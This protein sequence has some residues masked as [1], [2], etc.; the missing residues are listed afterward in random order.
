MVDIQHVQVD[1]DGFPGAP[2][3]SSFYTTD[4]TILRPQLKIFFDSLKAYLP[5]DVT[6]TYPASGDTVDSATG[7]LVGGWTDTIIGETG[8][9]SS[10]AYA[11]PVGAVFQWP[12]GAIVGR[13]RLKGRTF[14]VPMRGS[15]FQT[16]GSIEAVTL[17]ALRTAA[18]VLVTATAGAFLV[19]HRPVDHVG[20]S[21]AGVIG[22]IVPDMAAVLRSRRN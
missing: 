5:T 8:G 4:A 22:W 3:V 2:G 1:W 13:R 6:L 17:G 19:W 18:G 10:G 20:G 21:A 11:A 15:S 7:G 16:D 14:F 12:T 9:D